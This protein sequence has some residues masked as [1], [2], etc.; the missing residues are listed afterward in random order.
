V[1]VFV[2][3]SKPVSLQVLLTDRQEHQAPPP[4]DSAPITLDPTGSPREDSR[5][6][7]GSFPPPPPGRTPPIGHAHYI[8]DRHRPTT[9]AP[10][11]CS[12]VP[13]PVAMAT[14]PAEHRALNVSRYHDSRDTLHG[15]PNQELSELD[16]LYQASL[17]APSMHRGSNTTGTH[18]HTSVFT[19]PVGVY[20]VLFSL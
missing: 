2:L 19:E 8:S 12:S 3:S 17:R 9:Q 15:S 10:T 6:A 16:T 5:G 18:S 1:C 7:A 14:M 13:P 11:P 20:T 4:V